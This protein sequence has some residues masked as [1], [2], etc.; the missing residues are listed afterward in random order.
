MPV[1]DANLLIR[2]SLRHAASNWI[3]R[4]CSPYQVCSPIILDNLLTVA[5]GT[6]TEAVCYA[7]GAKGAHRKLYGKVARL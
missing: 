4:H 1:I 6:D 2:R 5:F 7:V 3:E